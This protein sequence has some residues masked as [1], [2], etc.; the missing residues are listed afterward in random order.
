MSPMMAPSISH[1]PAAKGSRARQLPTASAVL[2]GS[3]YRRRTR[4]TPGVAARRS[5]SS[6]LASRRLGLNRPQPN[7]RSEP[8]SHRMPSITN[9]TM[10]GPL[11][12]VTTAWWIVPAGSRLRSDRQRFSVRPSLSRI[13]SV[14][15][16]FLQAKALA[17]GCAAIQQHTLSAAAIQV[18]P[19][20]ESKN[21]HAY[22]GCGHPACPGPGRQRPAGAAGR[23]RMAAVPYRHSDPVSR[24][25]SF[26]PFRSNTCH[27]RSSQ[28]GSTRWTRALSFCVSNRY[29][30]P[31]SSIIRSG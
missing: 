19:Q 30:S 27:S 18:Q 20:L 13:S 24:R 31:S 29:S 4:M 5:V 25:V 17:V 2:K 26:S 28:T 6:P 12:T 9:V 15:S 11:S 14:L 1:L 23:A 8:P 10:Q 3:L 21:R 16:G 22:G 7:A